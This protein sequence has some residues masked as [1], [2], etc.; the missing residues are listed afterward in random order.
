MKTSHPFD[1]DFSLLEDDDFHSV[2][3]KSFGDEIGI[4]AILDKTKW[5]WVLKVWRDPHPTYEQAHLYCVATFEGGS[6][7][8]VYAD[9]FEW[10]CENYLKGG[11]K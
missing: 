7:G 2:Y 8:R 9:A 10:L 6:F 4:Q 3:G 11:R 5:H 1:Y